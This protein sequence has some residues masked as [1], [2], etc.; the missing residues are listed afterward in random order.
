MSLDITFQKEFTI[1]DVEDKTSIKIEYKDDEIFMYKNGYAYIHTIKN[2]NGDLI[3]DSLTR[4]GANNISD[5]MDELVITFQTKF[6]TDEEMEMIWRD[7]T[8]NIDDMF[9]NT[10]K[11][12][13][14]K[15]DNGLIYK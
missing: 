12:F 2:D 15:I 3:V 8:L 4:Y 6:I 14:Y 11:S 9:D 1:K 13:G 7:E 5:I 10:T